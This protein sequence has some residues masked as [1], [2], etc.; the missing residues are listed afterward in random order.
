MTEKPV[1]TH[2]TGPEEFD[3]LVSYHERQM[4]P[5]EG[6]TKVLLI[7]MAAHNMKRLWWTGEKLKN[8]TAWVRG[9]FP[10]SDDIR[11]FV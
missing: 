11:T 2:S 8:I 9:H 3:L 10:G 5:P 4:G 1:L 7:E 6:R